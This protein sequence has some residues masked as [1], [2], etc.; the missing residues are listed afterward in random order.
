MPEIGFCL[1]NK[2]ELSIVSLLYHLYSCCD[3][4]LSY[5]Q[6]C[7]TLGPVKE[8]QIYLSKMTRLSGNTIKI[9]IDFSVYYSFKSYFT[10]N[11]TDLH[12]PYKICLLMPTVLMTQYRF[13]EVLTQLI[14]TLEIFTSKLDQIFPGMGI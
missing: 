4:T 6:S 12:I 14:L 3:C 11:V 2:M 1:L 5:T 9:L 13:S 7:S 10:Y 8:L